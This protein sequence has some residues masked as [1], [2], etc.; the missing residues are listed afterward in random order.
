MSK[1]CMTNFDMAS[2][3]LFMTSF[4]WQANFIYGKFYLPSA[5]VYVQHI[6]Y[7]KVLVFWPPW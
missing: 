2:F 1:F 6:F 4:P 7:D 5:R 3:I